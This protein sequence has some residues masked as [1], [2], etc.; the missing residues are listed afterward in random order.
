MK[1]VPLSETFGLMH[2]CFPEVSEKDMLDFKGQFVAFKE[3]STGFALTFPYTSGMALHYIGV[4]EEARGKGVCTR[5][6]NFLEGIAHAPLYA[7]VLPESDLYYILRRRGW[8][9]L[10]I[11]YV[12]PSWGSVPEDRS[13]VLMTNDPMQDPIPFI[14]ELYRDGYW[15]PSSELLRLYR[16]QLNIQDYSASRDRQLTSLFIKCFG[17]EDAEKIGHMEARLVIE[18]GRVNG[19]VLYKHDLATKSIAVKWLGVAEGRRRNGLATAL[20]EML[21]T[22]FPDWTFYC[23]CAPDSPASKLLQKHGWYLVP[24]EW[25][26]PVWHDIFTGSKSASM[27]TRDSVN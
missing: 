15:S 1:L 10:L 2:E 19:F 16:N 8:E 26:C 14:Q 4:H 24:A 13:R 21:Y 11:S 18:D 22:T 17:P 25:E 5:M 9:R 27:Y 3:G 12:C 20:L 6:M 23:E 7:E